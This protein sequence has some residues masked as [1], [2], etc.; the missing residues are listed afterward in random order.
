MP[1][2]ADG[3]VL[4]DDCKLYYSATLGGAGTLTEI[5]VVIDDAI[6]SE[7]RS[8]ESNC[9][10]DAEISEHTG[11][12]KYSFTA[13][14]LFKRG[15]P[16]TTYAAMRTAYT[17]G[18]IH[19]YALASGTV[20]LASDGSVMLRTATSGSG[21]APMASAKVSVQF[22]PP[23]PCSACAR[24]GRARAGAPAGPRALL[25][26]DREDERRTRRV[27]QRHGG[28]PRRQRE[29][30]GREVRDAPVGADEHVLDL[31]LPS[32]QFSPALIHSH[33]HIGPVAGLGPARAGVDAIMHGIQ[34]QPIDDE[35]IQL[36]RKN[37]VAYGPTA[38]VYEPRAGYI[39]EPLLEELLEPA[40]L[41]AK[42]LENP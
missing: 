31:D 41:A 18:T 23:A 29:G 2:A 12:P 11:K 14:M 39:N 13:N 10:G 17:A 36:M 35:L 9:R 19:H 15:T 22:E 7:R 3:S 34:D 4:G 16:G 6:A 25:D 37:H 1:N 5:P 26:R 24:S 30:V 38:A 20:T 21:G 28:G 40:A 8:V 27:R 42:R 33:Q 32:A